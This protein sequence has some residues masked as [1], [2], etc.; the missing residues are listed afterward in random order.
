MRRYLFLLPLTLTPA[1]AEPDEVLSPENTLPSIYSHTPTACHGDC[2]SLTLY[3]ANTDIELRAYE[4]DRSFAGIATGTLSD[5]TSDELDAMLDALR[6]GEQSLGELP[7]AV[8]LDGQIIG[9]WLPG[10]NLSYAINHP[11]SGLVEID[12]LLAKIL[13]DLSQCRTN[14]RVD[15]D[16]DCE[17]LAYYP[18]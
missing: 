8:P 9:L 5:D 17:Q 2:R 11:P 7:A 16:S 15:S 14:V 12:T 4:P 18:E 3:R 6:S 1:C 13:D 10:L